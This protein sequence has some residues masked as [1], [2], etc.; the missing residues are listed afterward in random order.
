[1]IKM[2][3]CLPYYL[4]CTCKYNRKTFNILYLAKIYILLAVYIQQSDNT[5]FRNEFIQY[6]N[7]QV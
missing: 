7:K 5:W 3:S 6:N 1:M 4:I 2:Q